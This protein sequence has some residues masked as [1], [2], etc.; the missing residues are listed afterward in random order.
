MPVDAGMFPFM[1]PTRYQILAATALVSV[2]VLIFVGAVV[3]VT[4]SGMGCPDWPTCWGCLIPPTRIE[5]V[6][7]AKL[8]VEK[9]Q[10][11]AER[12]G[13][14][15]KVTQETLRR[16]FNPRHIWT[17]YINRLCSLPVGFSALALFIASFWQLPR[18]RSVFAASFG[19]LVLVLVNAWMGARVVYSGLRPGV[20]TTHLALAM[21]LIGVLTY[22]LWRGTDRPWR[23]ELPIGSS[24]RMRWAVALFLLLTVAEGIMGSQIRELTD[25]LAKSHSQVARSQWIG[26]LEHSW[27]FLVHRSFS[28]AVVA[29]AVFSFVIS[30]TSRAGGPR[31]IERVALGIVLLQ[32]VLGGIMARIHIH[33]VAQVLHVGLAAVLLAV[34]WLWNFGLWGGRQEE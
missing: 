7:F 18:R 2:L 30:R 25:E 26:E 13:R 22:T 11:K 9:F 10:K 33:A 14:N 23:V 17:E 1:R 20:L 34:L 12:L 27:I 28:W 16:D 8:P 19:A 3:R 32:M 6:D 5:Q 24:R 21:L 15:E 29:A 31:K 4:G